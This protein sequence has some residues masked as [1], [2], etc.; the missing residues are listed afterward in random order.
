MTCR[1]RFPRKTQRK[2]SVATRGRTNKRTYIALP[3]NH[4]RLNA[5]NEQL[6]RTW[7]GT[8]DLQLIADARGSAQYVTR[9]AHYASAATKPEKEA[10]DW[11][12]RLA[13]ERMQPGMAVRSRMVRI[14]NALLGAR[15]VPIQQ[16]IA[17]LLG[18]RVCPIVES[19]RQV[20][21]LNIPSAR[22][23]PRSSTWRSCARRT[24]RRRSASTRRR[25][26][27]SATTG[28][29]STADRRLF[30]SAEDEINELPA[31]WDSAPLQLFGQ[32]MY[33]PPNQ[34]LQEQPLRD[35]GQPEG[36]Q[37]QEAGGAA[38]QP[39]RLRQQAGRAVRLRHAQA[40]AAARL[41]G[42]SAGQ[43]G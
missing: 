35:A 16:A 36:G 27:W 1:F 6:M 28:G 11:R 32:W 31:P 29:R 14:A 5:Y 18:E 38:L 30:N 34:K 23:R 13:I 25:R 43:P 26:L 15:Q 21:V 10:L 4:C 24:T 9:V 19:S 12:L 41:R 33:V 17:V 2:S 22:R 42:G 8:V 39:V 7:R 20:V 3:R 37:A 40:V